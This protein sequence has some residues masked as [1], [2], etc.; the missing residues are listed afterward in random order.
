ML[1]LMLLLGLGWVTLSFVDTFK[2]MWNFDFGAFHRGWF[3][4]VVQTCFLSPTVWGIL[5][6]VLW[7]IFTMGVHLA[8][9]VV[10]SP[11]SKERAAFFRHRTPDLTKMSM[12]SVWT[13]GKPQR[14]PWYTG[15]EWH[16]CFSRHRC[17]EERIFSCLLGIGSTLSVPFKLQ[18]T[19]ILC[20]LYGVTLGSAGRNLL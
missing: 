18:R 20:G 17:M 13:V 12:N 14:Q 1:L 6:L 3:F 10:Y 7:R 19:K 11:V 15:L 8:L 16:G 9:S 2:S 5:S 4:L